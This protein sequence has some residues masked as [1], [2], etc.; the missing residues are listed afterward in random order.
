M[1]DTTYV[2]PDLKYILNQCLQNVSAFLL[3]V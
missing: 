1:K 2:Y 3:R